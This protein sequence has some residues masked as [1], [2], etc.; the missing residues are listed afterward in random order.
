MR[1]SFMVLAF[2]LLAMPAF[3][4]DCVSEKCNIYRGPEYYG[5]AHPKSQRQLDEEKLPAKERDALLLM[6][7]KSRLR[8]KEIALQ[9]DIKR[10]AEQRRQFYRQ[11]EQEKAREQ[12]LQLQQQRLRAQRQRAVNDAARAKQ[13]ARR[14]RVR[15]HNRHPR[16]TCTTFGMYTYCN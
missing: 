13:R 15:R 1:K 9:A 3:G 14:Q 10:R 5:V 2:V 7:E 12:A 16:L 11:A 8:Q 6:R 4:S